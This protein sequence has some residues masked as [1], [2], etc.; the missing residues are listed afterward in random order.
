[1][2][3]SDGRIRRFST[4]N[5]KCLR[6]TRSWVRSIYHQWSQ[7]SSLNVHH[8]KVLQEAFPSNFSHRVLVFFSFSCT[9]SGIDL[10]GSIDKKFLL[11]FPSLPDNLPVG[12]S[13]WTVCYCI[14]IQWV[15][16]S[17]NVIIMAFAEF[18]ICP[19]LLTWQNHCSRFS[20]F[21]HFLCKIHFFSLFRS[22]FPLSISHKQYV[23]ST[24]WILC[25]FFL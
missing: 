22:R 12:L 23:L 1:M 3:L 18:S 25:C 17:Q 16:F 2:K 9:V 11:F 10:Y 21:R 20:E 8:P 14:I 5:T 4:A 19:L 24:A 13:V 7:Y 15:S 6:W